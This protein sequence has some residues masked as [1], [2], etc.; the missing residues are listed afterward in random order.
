MNSSIQ[1][2]SL[3]SLSMIQHKLFVRIKD[4]S[5][6]FLEKFVWLFISVEF[7]LDFRRYL[8][9]WTKHHI[10]IDHLSLLFYCV[11]SKHLTDITA[12]RK[13]RWE[14]WKSNNNMWGYCFFENLTS[15]RRWNEAIVYLIHCLVDLI[16][17]RSR[18]IRIIT[19]GS[20]SNKSFILMRICLVQRICE[21]TNSSLIIQMTLIQ[22][23][24]MIRTKMIVQLVPTVEHFHPNSI[25]VLF[26]V[27]KSLR[28]LFNHQH[29]LDLNDSLMMKIISI[30]NDMTT[31][32]FSVSLR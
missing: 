26:I 18:F 11:C 25:E 19:D 20:M 16:I 5:P 2:P 27:I 21:Q 15:N 29:L 24:M 28:S 3:T 1:L 8:L 32:F 22:H 30:I 31:I 14:I 23:S 9:I 17:I 7:Y 4:F 6:I 12:Q 13:Y 10:R